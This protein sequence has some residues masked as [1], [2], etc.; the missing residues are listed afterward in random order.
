MPVNSIVV[1]ACLEWMDR[2]MPSAAANLQVLTPPPRWSTLRRAVVEA[3]AGRP[4]PQ[5]YPFE[6][7]TATAKKFLTAAQSEAQ[8]SGF[9]YIGTEHLLLAAFAEPRS[10]SARVLSALGVTEQA[11]RATLTKMLAAEKVQRKQGILPTS[12]VKKVI[13]LSFQLGASGSQSR[14]STGH[15][16]LALRAEGEGIAAHVLTDMSVTVESIE[17]AMGEIAESEV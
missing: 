12:R 7:F 10:V 11:V 6:R 1:A 2:H 13:E 8:K 17:S 4:S 3:M 15:I 5:V 9:S 14:V 16:L